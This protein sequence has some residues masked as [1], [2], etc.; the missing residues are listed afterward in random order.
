MTS[1]AL[2]MPASPSNMNRQ[3]RPDTTVGMA[4]GTSTAARMSARPRKARFIAR[5]STVPSAS[6]RVTLA[7]AKKPVWPSAAQKRASLQRLDVVVGADEG[8]AEPGHPEV[9]QVERFPDRPG[10][11]E[12]RDEQDGAEGGRDERPRQ[13]RLAALHAVCPVTASRNDASRPE[14][15]AV[16]QL[17]HLTRRLGERRRRLELP[18]ERAVQLD[19]ED[20]RELGVHRRHRAGHRPLD[21]RAR[22]ADR[23]LER[24]RE[25][26]VVVQRGPGGKLADDAGPL[27]HLLGPGEIL[28]H[29]PTPPRDAAL[30]ALIASWAPPSAAVGAPARA[31]RHR[32]DGIASGDPRCGAVLH[33]GVRRRASSA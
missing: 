24:P 8:P 23:H 28:D 3:S 15:R 2:A 4:Q 1:T 11:R 14:P 33:Q 5:A 32:R 16:E 19:L 27:Q 20:L 31:H 6:S 9:V 21:H 10:E 26:G 7:T 13:P 18:G 29:A 25:P 17:L 30:L 22:L 12:Q